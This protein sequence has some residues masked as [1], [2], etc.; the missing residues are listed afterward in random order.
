MSNVKK[1]IIFFLI[2][3]LVFL[4]PYIFIGCFGDEIWNYGFAYNISRGLVPY[5]DFNMIITPFYNFV[6]GF[7]IFIFGH[8][9]Y[10]MCIFNSLIITFLAF[11]IY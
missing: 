4:I 1:L 10:V 2:F 8:H 11:I 7:L 3:M 6:L 9:F 5:R